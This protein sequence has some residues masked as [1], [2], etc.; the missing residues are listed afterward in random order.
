MNY[1]K[2]KLIENFGYHCHI[3]MCILILDVL[4]PLMLTLSSFAYCSNESIDAS[5]AKFVP[6]IASSLASGSAIANIGF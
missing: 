3:C 5:L 1:D 4:S 2:A 6:Y